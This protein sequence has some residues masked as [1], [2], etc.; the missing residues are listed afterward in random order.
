M[1]VVHCDHCKMVIDEVA[2]VLTTSDA[3]R[4]DILDQRI[5]RAHLHWDCVPLYGRSKDRA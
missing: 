4:V 5:S 3:Q 2:Y 1:I